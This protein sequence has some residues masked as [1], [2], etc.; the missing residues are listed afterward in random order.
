[1]NSKPKKFNLKRI[2]WQILQLV[3]IINFAAE[4][5]NG[6][7]QIFFVLLPAGSKKEPQMDTP[8]DAFPHAKTK[9][10]FFAT[11]TWIAISG[12]VLYSAVIYR[13]KFRSF[14]K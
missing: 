10:R 7:Y 1:M 3:V 2:G 4:I 6:V 11:E 13:D 5:F 12:L 8:K 9:R 14:F